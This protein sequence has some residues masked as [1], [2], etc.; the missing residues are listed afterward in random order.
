MTLSLPRNL[1]IAVATVGLAALA[2][3]CGSS[4][5]GASTG[6]TVAPGTGS[7]ANANTKGLTIHSTS[8]GSVVA[9]SNGRTV[10]ELVG[11]PPSNPNCTGEC[12]SIWPPV[13]SGGKIAVVHGH[14]VF[15]YAND[16]AAGQTNGQKVNDTWGLWLALDPQGRPITGASASPASA[17]S[18]GS[19]GGYGY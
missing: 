15:T 1:S 8:L 17:P 18:S 14:P 7:T 19:G 6:Q 16:S 2:A 11:N 12:L 9:D 5:S 13:M 10:Y 4:S 3:G